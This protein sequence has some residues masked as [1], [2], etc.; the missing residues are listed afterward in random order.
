MLTC[1]S[2]RNKLI[3]GVSSYLSPPVKA[4]GQHKARLLVSIT[5]NSSNP[6]AVLYLFVKEEWL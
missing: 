4:S 3:I 1:H 6:G 5:P 2:E